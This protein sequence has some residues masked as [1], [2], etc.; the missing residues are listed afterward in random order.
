MYGRYGFSPT[1]TGSNLISKLVVI[2][3]S[4]ALPSPQLNLFTISQGITNSDLKMIHYHPRFTSFPH[5]FF[6]SLPLFLSFFLPFFAFPGWSLYLSPKN[7]DPQKKKTYPLKPWLFFLN[8]KR[9]PPFILKIKK[10]TPFDGCQ[11]AAIWGLYKYA[12]L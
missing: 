3:L 10:K 11:V 2:L 4:T 7:L 12:L 9:F 5:S 1:W 6:M 8:I